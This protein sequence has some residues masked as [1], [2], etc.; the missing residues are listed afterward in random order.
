V[1]EPRRAP[2]RSSI[3]EPRSCGIC[4][5]PVLLATGCG[6]HAILEKDCQGMTVPHH[7]PAPALDRWERANN[8]IFRAL[9][10]V[11]KGG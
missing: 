1:D 2:R 4:C 11:E 5:R 8:S 3:L 9:G 6:S 10:L 7:C